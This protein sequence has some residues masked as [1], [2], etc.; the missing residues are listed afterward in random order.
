MGQ[1]TGVVWTPDDD[2]QL[3]KGSASNK[4]VLWI[5]AKLKRS[6]N[7]VTTRSRLLGVKIKPNKRGRAQAESLR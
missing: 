7:S 6:M 2:D 5:A 4:S 3:R 1:K